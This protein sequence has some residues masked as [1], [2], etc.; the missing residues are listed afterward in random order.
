MA[1]SGARRLS[2]HPFLVCQKGSVTVAL[3]PV[4]ST[5]SGAHSRARNAV[6]A[7]TTTGALQRHRVARFALGRSAPRQAPNVVR[8]STD[9]ASGSNLVVGLTKR[10]L[11]TVL[12]S[13]NRQGW[14]RRPGKLRPLSASGVTPARD[15]FAAGAALRVPN[16]LSSEHKC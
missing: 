14:T 6:A 16:N 7:S 13:P 10:R 11:T 4:F 15:F 5:E 1:P 12:S 3:L 2:R 9:G 8:S